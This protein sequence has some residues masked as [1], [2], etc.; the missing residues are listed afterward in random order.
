MKYTLLDRSKLVARRLIAFGV[1]ASAILV[2]AG[3]VSS[4]PAGADRVVNGCTIVDSPTPTHHTKCE[5][6]LS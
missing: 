4:L 2:T 3:V 1:A 6:N 5:A